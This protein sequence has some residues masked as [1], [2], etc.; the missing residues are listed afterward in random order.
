MSYTLRGRLE[1]RL[2]AALVPLLAACVLAGLAQA[3]WPLQ[4]AALMLAVGVALDVI[5]YHRAL[6]YQPGWAALPLG[7]LELVV[8]MVAVRALD[9]EAPLAAALGLFAASWVLAQVLGHAALPLA[10]LSYAEEGGELGRAGPVLAAVVLAVLASSGGVAWALRPPTV[11]LAAGV[12]EGPLRIDRS[13]RLIGAPGA[14]VRGGIHV[15]ADDVTIRGVSV[16]GGE[17]GISVDGAED[18]VLDRV[19]VSGATL[20]GI[21]VRRSTVA[22]H[23][24]TVDARGGPYTQGIDI[25]YGFDKEMSLVEGCHV[26]GGQEGIVTHFAQAML[27]GNHVSQSSL[28]GIT[29]TEMSMGEVAR[30]R[31]DGAR[32]VGI[33][34]G[35][36]SMC[37]IERNRVSDTSLDHASGDPTRMGYGIEVHYGSEAELARNE[38][39]RSPGGIGSFLNSR[40]HR[41]R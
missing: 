6:P 20:D 37:T 41:E 32:G 35:D 27:R 24:C 1:S 40:I 13:Q 4:L 33:F 11:H 23:D 28:R 12:H 10:R 21:H 34:C 7:L 26:L 25:S 3:W 18:V 19:R 39:V 2:V 31:V 38:L 17:Y 8:V 36:H 30:N 29:M 9:V 16:V 5:V 15:T 14:V 22:I